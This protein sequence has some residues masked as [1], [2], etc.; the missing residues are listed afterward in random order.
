MRINKLLVINKT[1]KN[2]MNIKK[3]GIVSLIMLMPTPVYSDYYSVEVKKVDEGLY[4]TRKGLYIET[5]NQCYEN[6]DSGAVLKFENMSMDNKLIFDS[7][8]VCDVE[9][10]FK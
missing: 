6:F 9:K 4:K 1:R 2:I 5:R 3:F 7:G 10:I 8:T